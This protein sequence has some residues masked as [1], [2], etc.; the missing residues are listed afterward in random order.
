MS[1]NYLGKT[2]KLVLFECWFFGLF[3]RQ[4]WMPNAQNYYTKKI[5][6]TDTF[7]KI[8]EIKIFRRND[9]EVNE[10]CLSQTLLA[11]EDIIKGKK[12]QLSMMRD[13]LRRQ[14]RWRTVELASKNSCS[15][16]SLIITINKTII[17]RTSILV[18][19]D[20]GLQ[21]VTSSCLQ[22]NRVFHRRII[23]TKAV[24]LLHTH[25]F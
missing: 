20:N 5:T 13:R 7:W 12:T 22:N 21:T 14:W 10:L 25:I 11:R 1:P 16:N 6:Q 9:W 19:T 4:G 18:C 8:S 24:Y 15:R 3:L 2:F 17:Q 23:L